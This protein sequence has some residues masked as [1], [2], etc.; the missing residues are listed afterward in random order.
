MVT[1]E[2]IGLWSSREAKRDNAK[3]HLIA[4]RKSR[5]ER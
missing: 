3:L 5:F 2:M 4:N 1:S